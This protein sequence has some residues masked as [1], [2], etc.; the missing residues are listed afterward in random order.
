MLPETIFL[1]E[2]L[3]F[4]SKPSFSDWKITT[5]QGLIHGNL[6]VSGEK[7]N[8]KFRFGMYFLKNKWW[9]NSLQLK[10]IIGGE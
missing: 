1:T 4:D 10:P 8:I 7:L 9:L 2:T 6:S 3:N 5:A